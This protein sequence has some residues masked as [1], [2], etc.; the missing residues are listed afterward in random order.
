[1]APSILDQSPSNGN[2]E[3]ISVQCNE[4]GE[5]LTFTG[6]GLNPSTQTYTCLNAFPFE[7]YFLLTFAN[8]IETS[9]SNSITVSSVDAAGNFTTNDSSFVLHIDKIRPTVSVTAGSDIIQGGE[10]AIFTITITDGSSFTP[11]NPTISSGVI[12]S[13]PCSISPCQIRVSEANPG[14]LSLTVNQGVVI[15]AAGNTNLLT[16]TE[17]LNVRASNLSIDS[18]PYVT[19]SNAHGY[20]EVSGGCESSQSDVSITIEENSSIYQSASCNGGSYSTSLNVSSTTSDSLTILVSQDWTN[21]TV[22]LN[23]IRALCFNIET[24]GSDVIVRE[25]LYDGFSSLIDEECSADVIIPEGVTKI[26]NVVFQYKN[27]TSVT[28]P[29]SLT[30]I[31]KDAFSH[32]SLT[33]VI[34][35]NSITHI[36]EDAFSSNALTSI[37]IPDSVISIEREAFSGNLLTSVIIPD[38]ITSIEQGVFSSNN[39]T[40]VTIPN[41][42]T[43]LEMNAF[44]SNDLTS[45]TIPNGVEYIGEQA[46]SYNSLTSV[47]IPNSVTYIGEQAFGD[48][49]LNSVTIPDSVTY[50]A[51]EAFLNNANLKL[52]F[53]PNPNV[54]LGLNAFPY[55]YVFETH[56]D[57]FE[58]DSTDMNKIINYYDNENNN[59]NNSTCPRDVVIPQGI[60]SVGENAFQNKALTSVTM[61][62]SVVDFG[63]SAF[64]GN[65]NLE[66]VYIPHTNP[67]L[68]SNAFPNGYVR[69]YGKSMSLNCFEIDTTSGILITDY[70]DNEDNDTNNPACPKDV[71][72]PYGFTSIGEVAFLRNYLTSVTIPDSVVSIGISAFHTNHLTSVTIPDSV[73][74]IEESVFAYNSLTSV[75][76]PDSVVSIGISAFSNNS[77]T[78]VT[79]PDSVT[80]IEESVFAYNSYLTS[81]VISDS[82]I[83]IGSGAFAHCSLTSLAIPDSVTSIGDAAF[84][85][86]YSLTSVTIPSSV[87]SIGDAAF[88][89]NTLTSVDISE[90]VTSIGA[91]AFS[92]NS[93]TSVT[94]PDSVISIG[95]VAFTENPLISVIIGSGIT[96]IGE[97]AFYNPDFL[98]SV[99]IEAT[100]E[101]VT[102]V[103]NSYQSAYPFGDVTPT[104]DA[105]GDCTNNN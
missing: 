28:F 92:N 85:N 104:Y 55:G 12:I 13:E 74:S 15:D 72:I 100:E 47:T 91:S 56:N 6:T 75:T 35:P 83:S 97:V 23:M 101:D 26:S 58:F 80:S 86:N 49:N 5:I 57:C 7:E 34:L 21:H 53:L 2:S 24:N 64:F 90:G 16:V 31:G 39:L 102:L 95:A 17:S 48:N 46:F 52:V 59:S 38:S 4:I 19:S 61:P 50:I 68:G 88:R 69:G 20:V 96:S 8:N 33:S 98:N 93:L 1:M 9:S 30:H 71:E 18:S 43:R 105:D 76:I 42:I 44:I 103:Y 66:L 81:V 89:Y 36:G 54:S 40:S 32:N 77:L 63:D 3:S 37:T 29:N 99:C 14:N 65:P 87:I 62:N 82:V 45:I 78:S 25:Y 27:L 51:E 10:E 67:T 94:I 60:T 11:F 22:S 41:S 70:Y 73:T 79:I 84:A